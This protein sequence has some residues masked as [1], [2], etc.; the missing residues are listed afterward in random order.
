MHNIIIYSVFWECGTVLSL[1]G[2]TIDY[3]ILKVGA[4]KNIWT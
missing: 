2:H 3:K 4:E 1:Q